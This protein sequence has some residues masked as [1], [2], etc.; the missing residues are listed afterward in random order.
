MNTSLSK[1]SGPS[2]VKVLL[3]SENTLF[4]SSDMQTEG[5]EPLGYTSFCEARSTALP[6]LV[7]MRDTFLARYD[8]AF[9]VP[10]YIF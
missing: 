10:S 5:Y 3:K 1:Q 7:H 9:C 8:F 2:I 6:G 4:I